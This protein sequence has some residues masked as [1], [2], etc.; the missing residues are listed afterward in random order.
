MKHKVR[1][2]VLDKK[3]YPELQQ[4]YCMDPASGACPCYNAGDVFEFYRD[5]QGDDFWHMGINTLVTTAGDP[6][7][8]A[9]GP[10]LPFCSE[11][12]HRPA[13]R[14][15]HAGVDERG[16]HHDYLLLRRHPAG[17]I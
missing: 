16:K 10:R 9:G 11:A 3:L 1:V 15:H 2:T 14:L 7:A 5:G 6:D 8:V 13:G 12:L 17:H 4:A